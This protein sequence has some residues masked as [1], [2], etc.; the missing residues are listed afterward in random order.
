VKVADTSKFRIPVKAGPRV[1]SVA[2]VDRRHSAGVDELYARALARQASIDNLT[3]N[4]PYDPTGP[5]D[6]PSRRAI[7]V[8]Y[9]QE[10]QQEEPCARQI[11]TRL[12]TRGFRRP[13]TTSDPAVETLMQFYQAGR[14]SGAFEDG[15]QEAVARLLAD[16]QFLYRVEAEH[17]ELADGAIY[18]ISD[19]ELASRL[20]FFSGA[21]SRTTHC[22]I[23]PPGSS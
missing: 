10:A 18:H 23:S 12:A 7:F 2:I 8:C 15:I 1:I 6:T 9:P 11:L 13:M 21:A 4:G 16:P 20:S 22:W 14:E 17:P 3:I 19:I 5:G